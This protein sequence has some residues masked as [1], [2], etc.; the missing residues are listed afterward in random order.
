MSIDNLNV[1]WATTPPPLA[2]PARMDHVDVLSGYTTEADWSSGTPLAAPWP[3]QA[4]MITEF[5]G[6]A[7]LK[8]AMHTD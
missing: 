2:K 6:V 1:P 7:S 3:E 8:D 5:P 4:D